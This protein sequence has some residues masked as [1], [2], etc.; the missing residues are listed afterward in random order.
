MLEREEPTINRGLF[1]SEEDLKL[2]QL[3]PL[4]IRALFDPAAGRELAQRIETEQQVWRNLPMETDEVT[5]F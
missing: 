2:I 5:P 1:V 3:W 4:E